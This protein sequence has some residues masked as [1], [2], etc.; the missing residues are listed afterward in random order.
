MLLALTL[1]VS[2][3]CRLPIIS[4]SSIRR[5]ERQRIMSPR[6]RKQDTGLKGPMST[7]RLPWCG[8][9]RGPIGL[10][11]GQHPETRFRQVSRNGHLRFAMP[12]TPAKTVV[13]LTDV[14]VPAP[15]LI[16]HGTVGRFHKGPLQILIHIAA[17]GAKVELAPTRVLPRHQATVAGQRLGATEARHRANLL[18]RS[19]PPTAPPRQAAS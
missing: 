11:L 8:R 7:T 14:R 13:E 4:D 3:P 17:D 16:Q 19:P 15:R 5:L 6:C 1:P 9:R 2:A 18:S 10:A 12:P